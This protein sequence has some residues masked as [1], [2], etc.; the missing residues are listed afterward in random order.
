MISSSLRE[1]VA[2]ALREAE[3]SRKAIAPLAGRWPE[4][5]IADAYAIQRTN[6]ERRLE[7]GATIRGHKVGLSSRAMQDMM[8]VHEPDY[9][10]LLDD[11]FVFEGFEVAT[12]ELLQPRVEIEV[13]F[14]L[15][16]PLPKQGCN[17]ADVIRATE[18][19]LPS[20]EIIDSRIADWKIGIVD[21][22]ADNASSARVVLGGRP[23]RLD[24]IDVRGIGAALRVDG[25]IVE[26]GTAAAVLGNPVTSVAWLA[27][28]VGAF[29]VGLEAGHVILPGSCTR[30]V[31]VRP[32]SVVRADFDGLGH[33]DVRFV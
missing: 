21:T 2:R 33:V 5:G 12:A 24:Q 15:G 27:R 22:I 25:E 29:D 20:I 18:Y 32:G 23:L 9:G 31:P 17:A 28:T 26:T 4:I 7:A 14:V 3:D 30:A 13:A 10:H 6:I 11:M 16:A 19:I 8:G 1:E